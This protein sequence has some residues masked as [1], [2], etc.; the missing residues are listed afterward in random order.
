MLE[1]LIVE[2]D[3]S[4]CD[5]LESYLCEVHKLR[6]CDCAE[7]LQAAIEK[8]EKKHYDVILLDILL[9]GDLGTPLIA[10]AREWYPDKPPFII[11]MSAMHGACNLAERNKADYFLPKPFDL[12][13]LDEIIYKLISIN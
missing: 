6:N 1:I 2:D 7:T 8:V 5:T 12:E 3:P 13:T 10:I 4:I 9:N 11:V